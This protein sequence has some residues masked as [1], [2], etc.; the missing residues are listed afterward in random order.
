[1]QSYGRWMTEQRMRSCATEEDIL[2]MLKMTDSGRLRCMEQGIL[3]PSLRVMHAYAR[4][5]KTNL[6]SFDPALG[7]ILDI[8]DRVHVQDLRGAIDLEDMAYCIDATENKIR[9]WGNSA[10]TR[11]YPAIPMN[12]VYAI[13]EYMRWYDN[14]HTQKKLDKKLT[15]NI[16]IIPRAL[17][18]PK[19]PPKKKPAEPKPKR[20]PLT[21]EECVF[22]CCMSLADDP[23]DYNFREIAPN[24][25]AF[26]TDSY[27]CSCE[28][29][30]DGT[31]IRFTAMF[32]TT[33]RVC[34]N[35]IIPFVRH[36]YRASKS[37][38]ENNE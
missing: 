4:V 15:I 3:M 34:I 26:E 13:I 37:K 12:L 25:W 36:A 29:S 17:S 27:E 18:I 11:S 31:Q 19:P 20:P 28:L 1:M 9:K 6:A 5:G 23:A 16:P 33:G 32:K 10:H 2:N 24:K 30:P 14:G 7:R 38:E 21:T 22:I 8:L 35:R